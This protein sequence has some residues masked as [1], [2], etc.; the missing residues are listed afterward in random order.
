[1][2]PAHQQVPEAAVA[3]RRRE[4][5]VRPPASWRVREMR[6]HELLRCS[7]YE[8]LPDSTGCRRYQLIGSRLTVATMDRQFLL[9]C[10]GTVTGVHKMPG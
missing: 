6:V 9:Q 2:P 1:M 4:Q 7:A 3:E 5:R 8:A 10:T